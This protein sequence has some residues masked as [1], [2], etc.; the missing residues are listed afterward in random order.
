MTLMGTPVCSECGGAI[1][2]QEDGSAKCDHLIYPER[3]AALWIRLNAKKCR[4]A[5]NAA[6]HA[7]FEDDVD[8]QG[9]GLV[10]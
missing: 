6:R 1:E 7:E 3:D 5:Q 4:I 2:M 9:K 10:K 8:T